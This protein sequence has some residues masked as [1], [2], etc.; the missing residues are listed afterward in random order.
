MGDSCCAVAAPAELSPGFPTP[1]SPFPA[2]QPACIDNESLPTGIDNSSS[3][4]SS[5]PTARTASNSNAP[6]PGCDAAAIQ[7]ADSLIS[8]SAP[9]GAAQRLVIAS[10]TA[11][12]AAAAE[13]S[14][15]SGVRSPSAIASPLKPS[16]PA[17]VIAQSATGNCHGPT[18]WSRAVSPPTLRSPIVTRKFLHATVGWASTRNAASTSVSPCHCKAGQRGGAPRCASRC[19]FGGLPNKTSIGRLIGRSTASLSAKDAKDAKEGTRRDVL[20]LASSADRSASAS[21]SARTPYPTTSRSS[22]VAMPTTANGQRSRSQMAANSSTRSTG[23][24]TT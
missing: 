12:R 8:S 3:G 10:P 23:R 11:M 16:N 14:S 6:S 15:A 21:R 2:I 13:S 22:A 9:T 19:I 4:H 20:F 24:P 7:L 1:D 18:I 5:N 17:K